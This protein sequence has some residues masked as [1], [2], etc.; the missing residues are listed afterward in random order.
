MSSLLRTEGCIIH[1][2]PEQNLIEK[3]NIYTFF[4]LHIWKATTVTPQNYF[5]KTWLFC[6]QEISGLGVFFNC[7]PV[8]GMLLGDTIIIDNLDAANHYRKEVCFSYSWYVF[9]NKY[10][11][12][13]IFNI[14]QLLSS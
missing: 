13:Y 1:I 2:T 9:K 14:L 11:T 8:F 5:F 6:C 3:D 12:G 4:L 10:I 7:F